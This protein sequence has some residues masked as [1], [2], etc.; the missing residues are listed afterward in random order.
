MSRK[1]QNEVTFSE[2][3]GEPVYSRQIHRGD[4]DQDLGGEVES[5][6][7]GSVTDLRQRPETIVVGPA[8]NRYAAMK[9]QVTQ[10]SARRRNG[11]SMAK[12]VLRRISGVLADRG[13][14]GIARQRERS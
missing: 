4:Q 11:L 1:G 2:G 13:A 12:R 3:G 14:G 6:A 5:P 7:A 9:P 8:E 10:F